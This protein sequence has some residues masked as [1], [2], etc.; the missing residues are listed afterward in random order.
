[1]KLSLFRTGCDL[2]DLDAVTGDEIEL[3]LSPSHPVLDC[4]AEEARGGR[5]NNEVL[6]VRVT[7]E[8]KPGFTQ[9]AHLHFSVGINDR[10]QLVGEVTAMQLDQPVV[11][12]SAVAKWRRPVNSG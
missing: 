10:D 4:T 9:V 5:N 12:K 7:R 8:V 2:K 6:H 1:M 11:R 3:R